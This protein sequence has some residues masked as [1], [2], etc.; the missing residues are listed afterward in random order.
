MG[1]FKKK[2]LPPVIAVPCIPPFF[3]LISNGAPP[4]PRPEK[5][6]AH[7]EPHAALS[8]GARHQARDAPNA[9]TVGKIGRA[10]FILTL[11]TDAVTM[12][13]FDP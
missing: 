4:P 9:A 11:R 8:G 3:M 5:R 7:I 10:L 2:S 1:F 13:T 12:V 6:R